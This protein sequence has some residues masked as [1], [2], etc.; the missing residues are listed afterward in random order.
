MLTSP[1]PSFLAL[2]K[3]QTMFVWIILTKNE[4]NKRLRRKMRSCI[5]TWS[6]WAP[7]FCGN[8]IDFCNYWALYELFSRY[9]DRYVITSFKFFFFF[10]KITSF[11]F[12]PSFLNSLLRCSYY[13]I[14]TL[15]NLFNYLF[16]ELL[17][18][19]VTSFYCFTYI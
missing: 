2:L 18:L 4:I 19:R 1:F 12:L 14:L 5:K 7:P 3:F 6:R 15:Y 11:K 16:L 10:A 8:P 17:F 13:L 9:N